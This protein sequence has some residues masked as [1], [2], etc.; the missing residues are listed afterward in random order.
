MVKA[1]GGV[2]DIEQARGYMALVAEVLLGD[3]SNLHRVDSTL[4]R[5]GASSLLPALRQDCSISSAKKRKIEA[6]AKEY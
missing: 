3:R 6:D 1:A 2:R 5:F 4:L